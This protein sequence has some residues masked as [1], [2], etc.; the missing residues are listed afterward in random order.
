MLISCSVAQEGGELT[1]SVSSND[2]RLNKMSQPTAST[3]GSKQIDA[4]PKNLSQNLPIISLSK[5]KSYMPQNQ[6][7]NKFL[8]V[9]ATNSAYY[10]HP[11]SIVSHS[12]DHRV[13]S[14]A[15]GKILANCSSVFFL[16]ELVPPRR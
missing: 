1:V 7:T 16:V 13:Q 10:Q 14:A 3:S 11:S 6:L 12:V 8:R 2:T 5:L 4:K 9:D 15:A